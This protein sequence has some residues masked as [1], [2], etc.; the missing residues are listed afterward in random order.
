MKLIN[1]ITR[2]FPI[3]ADEQVDEWMKESLSACLLLESLIHH[4][5]Q[6]I[7]N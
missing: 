1:G 3:D 6:Y 4:H 7:Y 5:M 2:G